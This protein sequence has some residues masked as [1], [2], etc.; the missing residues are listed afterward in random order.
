MQF[1]V[2]YKLEFTQE[3]LEELADEL[4]MIPDDETDTVLQALATGLLVP[5][6]VEF[7]V[8]EENHD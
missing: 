8:Q 6:N 2:S 5:S 3:E 4:P 7:D 1:K